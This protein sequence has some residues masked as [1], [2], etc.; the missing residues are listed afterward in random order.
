MGEVAHCQIVLNIPFV[1]DTAAVIEGD[2]SFGDD[3]RGK[4]DVGSDDQVANLAVLGDMI[5]GGVERRADGYLLNDRRLWNT[6]SL[7]GDHD[8]GER[9]ALSNLK[10]NLF[11][12]PGCGVGI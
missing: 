8:D 11:Q 12:C 1:E 4:R 6:L 7:V 5:V 3:S 10:A 2:R 9:A